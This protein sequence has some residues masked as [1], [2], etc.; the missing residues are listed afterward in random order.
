M[1]GVTKCHRKA[2]LVDLLLDGKGHPAGEAAGVGRSERFAL[3][4]NSG[5]SALTLSVPTSAVPDASATDVT[6]LIEV[7]RP[8]ARDM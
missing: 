2:G 5:M 3:H 1:Y 7:H 4:S 8:L 6:I